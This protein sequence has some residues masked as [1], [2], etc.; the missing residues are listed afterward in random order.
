MKEIINNLG[1]KDLTTIESSH[2]VKC[3]YCED[4]VECENPKSENLINFAIK[5][6][7]H[8]LNRLAELENHPAFVKL[9]EEGKELKKR[10]RKTGV[11]IPSH[12]F[13]IGRK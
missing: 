3:L 1:L 2:Y 13:V 12:L 4:K 9:K 6:I 11:G 7:D 10:L 5:E 8:D